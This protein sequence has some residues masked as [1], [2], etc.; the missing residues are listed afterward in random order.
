MISVPK[1]DFCPE[2]IKLCLTKFISFDKSHFCK[3]KKLEFSSASYT[4]GI[5]KHDTM[6]ITKN[7]AK[8]IGGNIKGGLFW[9]PHTSK[10]KHL[11][12]SD[13]Y[14]HI[15]H[16]FEDRCTKFR[17]LVSY[18]KVIMQLFITV[19]NIDFCVACEA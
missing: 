11:S 15:E 16:Y 12:T 9:F 3:K 13:E 17:I 14:T 8:L 1:S 5:Q 6:R 10:G 2:R 18:I 4:A 19:T 7:D